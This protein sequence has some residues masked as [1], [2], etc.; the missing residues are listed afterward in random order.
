MAKAVK[1]PAIN[2]LTNILVKN[3]ANNTG[4]SAM[5]FLQINL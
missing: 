4:G 3:P 1:N 2:P 5:P